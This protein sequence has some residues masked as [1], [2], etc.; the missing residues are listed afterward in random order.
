MAAIAFAKAKSR[1]RMMACTTS[2]G[3]GATNMVT[4][5]AVA[6]VNRLPVLLLPGDVFASRRPDPV[7]Q[8]IEDFGDAT[9]S[10]NDCFRPV[11]RW[12]DRIMRP[13]QLLAALP[14]RHARADRSR[15]SAARS[16]SPCAR[17]CRPRPSTIPRASSRQRVWRPRAPGRRRATNCA[18]ASALLRAAKRPLI[19]AGGGVQFSERRRRRSRL[20]RA[21][22][23]CRSPRPRPARA[24]WPGTTRRQWARSASP[25]RRRPTRWPREADLVLAVGTRLQDFTTG[26]RALF[27]GKATLVELNVA[28]FDAG[29]HGAQPLV[30]DAARGLAELADGAGRLAAP[31]RLAWRGAAPRALVAEWNAAS[32]AATEAGQCRLPTD[33]QVLGAVNRAHA[34]DM[35]SWSA[36][37]AGCRASCTSCGAPR[38]RGGY[39]MEYGY[40]CMGYEIAGGLGVK[41]ALPEREVFV[42]GRRR[43]LP[44]DEHRDRD[45][46]RC[47]ARS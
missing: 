8:Q 33:A 47:S 28:A 39:H 15:P 36:P 34:E 22:T 11:S 26:S 46:G 3:P 44:D 30:G 29:K 5:A 32:T 25:A 21:A 1:R 35:A 20:R 10:A 24:R 19:V 43:Q 38:S 41:M 17:T 13:E 42:H 6:H 31:Q 40:S 9:V 45:L 18:G 16:R 27:P 23:A 12:F 4:A 7:L 2:I 14:P 37:P